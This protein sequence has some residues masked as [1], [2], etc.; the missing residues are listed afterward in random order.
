MLASH[1]ELNLQYKIVG[2]FPTEAMR[3][4]SKT[5]DVSDTDALA[6]IAGD[7]FNSISCPSQF[8]VAEELVIDDAKKAGKK[9]SWRVALSERFG[10]LKQ[11]PK[12]FDEQ[13]DKT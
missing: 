1:R 11:R 9:M 7:Y 10:E 12:K 4:P 5:E 6:A 8:F 13:I 3:R 2:H